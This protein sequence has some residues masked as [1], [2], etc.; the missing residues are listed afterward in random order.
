MLEALLGSPQ[1]A[2]AFA[3]LMES[4]IT[5]RMGSVDWL[6]LGQRMREELGWADYPD[7]PPAVQP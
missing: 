2:E 4:A 1:G 7:E 5:P 6:Q 3:R